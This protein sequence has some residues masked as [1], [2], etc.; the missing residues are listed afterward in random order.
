MTPLQV[1]ILGCVALLFLLVCSLPVAIVMGVVGV[2]GYAAVIS[3]KAALSVLS[4]DLYDTF[5]NY[6]LTVIPLFVFMGQVAFHAGISGRLFAAANSWLSGLRGGLAM[7]TV[8]AC[9]AFGAICGSG[10]AT[11]ATM[12]A[13]ALPEMKKFKYDDALASGT[14]AAGGSLGMLIP[15]SVVFIVYGILTEQ[16]I[17]KLFISGII[18]GIVVALLFC[19]VI[20]IQCHL[21]PALAPAAVRIAWR[22]R[23]T[24]LLGVIETLVLFAFVM[25]GMFAGWFTPTEG[26]A[27][28]A[29]G[30]VAIAAAGRNCSFKMLWQAAHETIR[31]SC[32][33]M[34]IVAGATMFGHFLAI[35]GVPTEFAGWLAAL[36]V[37]PWMIIVMIIIFYL[38]A[39]CFIDAL[40]LILLTIPIFYPVIQGLGYNGI[41]FGVIIVLV[42]Q[43]GVI[44]P[45]VG[46]NAYVVSGIDRSI[47]LQTVFRGSL[48]F[49]LALFVACGL[50]M[51]FPQLA[52]WLPQIVK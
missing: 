1:G 48:P 41:W 50:L 23:F 25:G 8:G 45:P 36:P 7:A 14:V 19:A 2:V 30:S 29:A 44:T 34:V 24:S 10:P 42:T 21:N 38:V 28:G 27:V 20:S 32:M 26:A 35:T 13:V 33:V 11:A 51:A 40:A 46:V 37:P 39:G 31:T 12:A 5:S 16:S 18:P 6:N 49:L 47:P 22:V 4:A 17:G 43:M 52:T 3:N 15:P 9:A